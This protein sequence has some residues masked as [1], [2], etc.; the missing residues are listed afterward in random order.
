MTARD[1][2]AW[3]L[4]GARR[5]TLQLA[6]GI[7][8]DHACAQDLPG[9]HHPVWTL[10]HLVLGDSYLLTLLGAGTLPVDFATLLRR[11]GPGAVPVAS[12]AE[13]DSLPELVARLTETE[14]ARQA[15]LAR[16]S[17]ADLSRPT[18][19]PVLARSQPALGHH[20]QALVGHE[21]YH[22]GQ[23]MAWR[24]R[25]GLPAVPWS[26][27]PPPAAEHRP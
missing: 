17:D 3:A 19:D 16:L 26:F 8:V 20:L 9:E 27:A 10:G 22:A 14:T 11:Y 23:L 4:G 15:A 21:G 6:S 7:P 18:P 24:R 5:H 25:R 12:P 2:L 1:F 13:Y